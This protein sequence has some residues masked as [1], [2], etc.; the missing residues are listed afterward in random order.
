MLKTLS[1]LIVIAVTILAL[2]GQAFAIAS[3]ECDMSQHSAMSN[4]K[5]VQDMGHHMNQNIDH[6]M[7]SAMADMDCCDTDCKCPENACST[8]S[9]L[10]NQ[11]PFQLERRLLDKIHY[12]TVSAPDIKLNS[13]FR[14]PIIA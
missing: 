10:S 13:L 8:I 1:S 9:L 3:I 4:G 7:M 5:T 6:D 11:N 12:I 14:P 2:V